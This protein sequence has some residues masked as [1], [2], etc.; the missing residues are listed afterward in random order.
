V[1]FLFKDIE[2]FKSVSRSFADIAAYYRDSGFSRGHSDER[3]EPEFVQ[4]S[5]LYPP[6]LPLMGV[7]PAL[8]RVFA[9]EEEPSANV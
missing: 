1:H 8:E 9:P 6:F 5:H 7:A 4:G 3:E 2:S